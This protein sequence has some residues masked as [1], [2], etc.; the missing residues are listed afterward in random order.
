MTLLIVGLAVPVVGFVAWWLLRSATPS[1]PAPTVSDPSPA[2]SRMQDSR[3][4]SPATATRA[5]R[6]L[7]AALQDLQLTHADQANAGRRTALTTVFR[8]V[9]R[10]PKLLHHLVSPDFFGAASSAQLV[11]LISAEPLI[12]AKVLAAVNSPMY[13]LSREVTSVSQAVN[14]LGL[15]AVRAL[16]L[17]YL[18]QNAFRTDHPERQRQ[19]EQTWTASALASEL[20]QRLSG[21]LAL[22]D[23]GPL[24]SAVVLS[25]LGR[26]ATLAVVP[27][28]VLPRIPARTLVERA[29]AEEQLLGLSASE[30]GRLLMTEWALP[31]SV[32]ADAADLNRLLV[33]PVADATDDRLVRLAVG[34]LGARLGERLAVGELADL[35]TF[36]LDNGHDAEI[37]HAVNHLPPALKARLADALLSV[38]L[39]T[40]VHRLLLALQPTAGTVPTASASTAPPASLSPR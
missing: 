23:R 4:S 37:F 28:G 18:M 26:L 38:D 3:T 19:L 39:R 14:F 36:D 29:R 8:E 33:T 9:P 12:A 24:V 15:N 40:A 35:A 20:V 21:A 17:Q 32:V 30:I 10:P 6:D 1:R 11:D 31:A 13:G 2:A 25:F 34:Y 7:P 22:E 5:A 27:K 16:C